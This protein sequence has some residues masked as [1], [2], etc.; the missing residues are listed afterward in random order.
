MAEENY[1]AGE[2]DFR[3]QMTNI[4][5]KKPDVIY[6]PGYYTEVANIAVQARSLGIDAPLLGGDGWDSPKLFEIGGKA[7]NG[8]YLTNHYSMENKDASQSSSSWAIIKQKIRRSARRA[9]G[10][11][12]R[13][14]LHDVRR[15]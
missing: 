2:T 12:L 7:V 6:I 15:H 3:A 11:G 4:K 1:R 10:C 8:S 5:G 13:C 14:R 9:G